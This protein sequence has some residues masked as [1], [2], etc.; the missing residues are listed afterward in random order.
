MA[1]LLTPEEARG[2]IVLRESFRMAPSP[3]SV[4]N[5]LFRAIMND[6]LSGEDEG[7]SYSDLVLGRAGL[8]L[9]SVE[10]ICPSVVAIPLP[11][12]NGD[13]PEQSLEDMEDDADE[14]CLIAQ[15]ILQFVHSTDTSRWIEDR[16]EHGT[17][18]RQARFDDIAI[19][20]RSRTHLP[21]LEQAFR[22]ACIPYAVAKGAGFYR[23]QEILD[24]SGYLAFLAVPSNDI[25]LAGILRSP[26]F[27]FSDVDLFKLAHHTAK[28]S[29]I[30]EEP[31]GLWG[32][33]SG[34]RNSHSGCAYSSC[35]STAS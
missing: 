17:A 30:E 28:K 16:V 3:M 23:Q 31:W 20:L 4:I 6:P 1:L 35:G 14:A 15:K 7:L 2:E 29:A 32:E 5:I 27:A 21:K 9:G 34:L 12:D 19:L 25:A 18:L 22:A 8:T 24:I 26:D 11:V 10:W 13:E 33:T